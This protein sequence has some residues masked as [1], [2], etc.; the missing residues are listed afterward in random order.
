MIALAVSLAAFAVTLLGG[1]FALRFRERLHL[2]LGFSAGAVL[3][4][5]FLDLMPEAAQLAAP[6]LELPA[7]L[8]IVVAGFVAYMLLDRAAPDPDPATPAGSWRRGALGA[9]S[10]CLHSFFDGFAIG[11]GFKASASIG[12]V[13]SAAV[14]AHDFADG[15]NTV[16]AVLAKNG[17][18]RQALLWLAI[19]AC[20]PVAGAAAT[21][22]MHLPPAALGGLLALC[23]GFFVYM[24]ASDLL[25]ESYRDHPRGLTTLMTVLGI[26]TIYVVTRLAAG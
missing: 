8:A 14:L 11:L 6:A 24:S 12:L 19:N 1:L 18:R 22:G 4:V 5:A 13:V 2:I 9:A 15:I 10:L 20:A 25:P 23:S 17:V 16:G 21:L 26:V 3:G 7:V